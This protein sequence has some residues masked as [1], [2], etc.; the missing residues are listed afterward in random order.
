M[1]TASTIVLSFDNLG[2]AS[3][4]ERGEWPEGKAPGGHPSVTDALPRLLAELGA[5]RLRASFCVEAINCEIYPD[6]LAGIAAAGHELALHGWRHEPWTSLSPQDERRTLERGQ[7]AFAALGVPVRGFRP[8]GGDL[9]PGSDALLREAGIDWCSPAGGRYHRIP[10]GL[11]YVPFDWAMVD[12]YHLMARFGELRS[13]RGDPGEPEPPPSAGE[14]LA[15]RLRT[16]PDRG[17]ADTL[18]LHPFLMLDPAWFVQV[19]ALLSVIAELAASGEVWV[20]PAGEFAA[21]MS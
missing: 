13:A 5:H 17:A 10:G 4:L 8:P 11:T 9:N 3:E 14:R 7:A 20:T 21:A 2:E 16:L 15:D 18:I 19:R 1:P 12:A 6:A